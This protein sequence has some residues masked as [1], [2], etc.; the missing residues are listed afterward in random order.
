MQLGSGG[1]VIPL[2][3]ARPGQAHDWEPAK[4]NFYCS[5]GY[6]LTYLFIFYVK[7]GAVWQIFL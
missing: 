6:R 3:T 2:P 1:D 4:L 5:K 7:F